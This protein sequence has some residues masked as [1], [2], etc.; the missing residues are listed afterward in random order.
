[1]NT[2]FLDAIQ[3]N[4]RQKRPPVWLM[5]QAGRYLP[6][7]RA[8]RSK[9][10]LRDMFFT[11]QIAADV[12]LMPIHRFG[13][14]AAIIFSDIL[15][16][17]PA[18]G[19]DLDFREG[20]VVT[21]E[22][23]RENWRFLKE[24]LSRLDPIAESIMLVKQKLTVPLIGFCGG[25]YTIATYLTGDHARQ[26]MQAD[27]EEFDHFLEAICSLCIHSLQKQI[28]A[29]ADVIQIFDS[30][31]DQLVGEEFDRWSLRYLKRIANAVEVPAIVF[32]RGSSAHW[33][34]LSQIKNVCLSLDGTKKMAE[35][36]RKVN[37]ALQGNLDP[38][39]LFQPLEI[40]RKEVR[41]LLNE[42]KDD[43]GFIVNLAHGVK[44]H[45]P[46]DAVETLV[47]EVLLS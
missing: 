19:C 8:L 14:D 3:R 12:T 13:F 26:W 31:A 43:P 29:G 23:T 44:P 11:P 16:I 20:P 24:D 36:R 35:I 22:V 28:A 40:V 25:P 37:V 5:R 6:E 10:S 9:H 4:N 7:Y 21:P 41:F 42:M 17:A 45:T 2:I 30:W 15:A 38:D 32:L 39:L 27:P 1:V 46:L 18:F 47:K 34:S 33:E